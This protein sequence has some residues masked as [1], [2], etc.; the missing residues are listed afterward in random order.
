MKLYK[1]SLANIFLILIFLATHAT[2]SIQNDYDQYG[3]EHNP[4]G[5][6]IGGGDGYSDMIDPASADFYVTDK[7]QLIDALNSATSGDVVYVADNAE[8]DLSVDYNVAIP[9]GVTLASGRGYNGS[10]G[11]KLYSGYVGT[12]PLFRAG[13]SHV[14][15]T[16]LRF[17][18]PDRRKIPDGCDPKEEACTYFE[19]N[20]LGIDSSYPYLEVDNCELSGWSYAAII[21]RE[22][23]NNSFIHHNYIHNN[24]RIGL[25]YGVTLE[26]SDALMEANIFDHGRHAIAGSGHTGTSYEARYNIFRN[27]FYQYPVDMHGGGDRKGEDLHPDRIN[28]AGDWIK[29]HHNS[30]YTLEVTDQVDGYQGIHISG[31]PN[32]KCAIFNNWFINAKQSTV[33][34]Q[35]IHTY[36]GTDYSNFDKTKYSYTTKT[37]NLTNLDVFQNK[38]GDSVWGDNNSVAQDRKKAAD[39]TGDGILDIITFNSDGTF[40]VEVGTRLGFQPKARWGSNGADIYSR[41][42]LGDFNGDGKTDVISF[43]SN[44]RF[45]VW[46][47][48]GSSF[49]SAR[50]W[51]Q[52]GGDI[53]SNRYKIGDFNGDGKDDVI[54]LEGNARFYVWRS[55]GSGFYSARYWGQNGGDIGPDRYK[56]GDLNGDGRDDLIS[57]EGNAR[58]YAWRSYGSGFYNASYWGQNGGDIGPNRYKLGYNNGDNILDVMACE[59]NR[60]VYRWMGAIGGGLSNPVQWLHW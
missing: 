47:S 8:I 21:L 57:F 25:G 46:I 17:V 23:S 42:K 7:T 24:R 6:P 32:H 33:I 16:G 48:S 41:Y 10:N 36:T 4:T 3:A 14:R 20:S 2:A 58:F 55:Y 1:L 31:I 27:N 9:G 39:F 60:R 15:I 51:G 52:N 29:I 30:F 38:Y 26:K 49:Y 13:G 45:Y 56:I 43:E 37:N 34:S 44:Y 53:G 12:Y 50:Y 54:S 35:R 59:S 5:N 28:V 18:G 11:A 19:P 40:D 22:G